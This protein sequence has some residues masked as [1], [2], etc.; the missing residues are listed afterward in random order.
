V[1]KIT[2]TARPPV[3]PGPV[4]ND[5]QQPRAEGS[6]GTEAAERAEG[7]DEGLLCD[8]FCVGGRAEDEESRA[9]D[10]LLMSAHQRLVRAVVAA[11]R[12]LD[13]LGL[14]GPR[15]RQRSHGSLGHRTR[16]AI[17]D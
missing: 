10:D 2:S 8:V 7:L 9:E 11:P 17:S 13:E 12:G 1:V 14:L 3:I 4:A 5:P 15:R 6:A 16:T